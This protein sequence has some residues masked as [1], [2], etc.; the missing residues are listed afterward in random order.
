M[1]IHDTAAKSKGE[2][3]LFRVLEPQ[4]TR[5]K[6]RRFGLICLA[7]MIFVLLPSCVKAPSATTIDSVDPN[8]KCANVSEKMVRFEGSIFVIG[9]RHSEPRCYDDE[10]PA[11]P[12]TLRPFR[13]DAT[14]VTNDHYQQCVA[15]GACSPIDYDHCGGL[16][17]DNAEERERLVAGFTGGD[18][19]AVC[20]TWDQAS[21][22]CRWKGK[23]LPTEAE[24]E[25]AV[26]KGF[27]DEIP[28]NLGNYAWI[29]GNSGGSTHPVAQKQPDAMGQYDLLG[30]AVEW[31]SDW[32]SENYYSRANHEDPSGPESGIEKVIRGGSWKSERSDI[33]LSYRGRTEPDSAF[34]SI[35][36][37]CAATE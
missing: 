2:R 10:K 4:K 23:R 15:A 12:V 3:R 26:T 20:V 24:W 17:I 35:G 27:S 28:E 34:S 30:N 14:E 5:E 19:P 21:A 36:F 37:R 7:G 6:F 8:E 25:Y 31:C 9:C 18:R 29:E 32:W 13:M 11:H 22:H 1:V 16:D 33:R